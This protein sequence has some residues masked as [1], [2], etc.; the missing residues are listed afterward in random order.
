MR[1]VSP[2]LPGRDGAGAGII[3]RGNSRRCPSRRPPGGAPPAL[4]GGRRPGLGGREP[5]GSQLLDVRRPAVDLVDP[6]AEPRL[7]RVLVT[8]DGIP[9]EVEAVVAV[10]GALDV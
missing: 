7:C 8:G 9:I 6:L 10:V 4:G 3:K 1:A 5:L 2:S